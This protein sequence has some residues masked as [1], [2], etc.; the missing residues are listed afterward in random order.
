[1]TTLQS[2]CYDGTVI[3]TTERRAGFEVRRDTIK[4]EQVPL[5]Q[6]PLAKVHRSKVRA[7]LRESG[8]ARL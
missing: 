8:Q 3:E 4:Q 2:R 5:N 1:M 6:G 7:Y